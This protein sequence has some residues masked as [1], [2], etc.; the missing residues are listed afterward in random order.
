MREHWEVGSRKKNKEESM[1]AWDGH[2]TFILEVRNMPS[3]S[4]HAYQC[5]CTGVA[6]SCLNYSVVSYLPTPLFAF[7]PDHPLSLLHPEARWLFQ[8]YQIIIFPSKTLKNCLI[9][10]SLQSKLL[11]VA[12]KLHC[13]MWPFANLPNWFVPHWF[14][15]SHTGLISSPLTG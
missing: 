3:N 8:K 1:R 15:C 10:V 9:P 5:L 12:T 13:M 6:F 14:P 2:I 7:A 11:T 4:T